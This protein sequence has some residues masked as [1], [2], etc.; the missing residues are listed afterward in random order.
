MNLSL[1]SSQQEE[2]IFI[3]NQART[4][5]RSGLITDD[6]LTVVL[7]YTN[8][9]VRQTNFFFRVIFFIFT[10]LCANALLGLF[11]WIT[12][13]RTCLLYTSDAADEEDSVDLGG[14]R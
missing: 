5:K 8:P 2:N 4:W 1:Y 12:G 7:D 13:I 10:T 9:D 6:Q 11:I 14:T 3:R